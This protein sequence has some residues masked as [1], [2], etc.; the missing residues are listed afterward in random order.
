MIDYIIG[1]AFL[2]VSLLIF[3]NIFG[4][5]NVE[6]IIGIPLLGIA[7][8]GLIIVQVANIMSAHINKQWITVSWILCA[9][10]MW[11]SI[12]YLLS[13]FVS[14]PETLLLALPAIIASFLFVEGIYSFYID[15]EQR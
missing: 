12:I 9:V 4:W 8:V 10:M 3:M 14:F 2:P 1:F 13:G 15:M 11:P 5:T 6:N 7:A